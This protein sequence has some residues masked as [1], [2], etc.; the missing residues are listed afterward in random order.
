MVQ[1]LRAYFKFYVIT[2]KKF[3]EIS[4]ELQSLSN[5][6]NSKKSPKGGKMLAS[7]FPGVAF[8]TPCLAMPTGLI[9]NLNTEK[10]R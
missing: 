2:I 10:G 9:I 8:A 5:N 1:N 6:K 4:P 7:C 3:L